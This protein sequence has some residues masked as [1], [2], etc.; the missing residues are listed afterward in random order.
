MFE[1]RKSMADSLLSMLQTSS[2]QQRQ[3]S[4]FF[5]IAMLGPKKIPTKMEGNHHGVT[6]KYHVIAITRKLPKQASTLTSGPRICS[7]KN[8]CGSAYR[9]KR[10]HVF[11]KSKCGLCLEPQFLLMKITMSGYLTI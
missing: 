1:G 4:G 3:K 2:T 11:F 8:A 7:R 6:E 5:I 10:L 9:G